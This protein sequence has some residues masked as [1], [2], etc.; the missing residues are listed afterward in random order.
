MVGGRR[1]SRGAVPGGA[2]AA[3]RCDP[4]AANPCEISPAASH[5][6]PRRHPLQ[7]TPLFVRCTSSSIEGSTPPSRGS[8]ATRM[9]PPL[10]IIFLAAGYEEHPIG[11]SLPPS[12]RAPSSD[13]LLSPVS[14]R[15]QP[16]TSQAPSRGGRGRPLIGPP[17]PGRKKTTSRK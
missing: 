3:T 8:R 9:M 14:R 4:P 12:P 10:G 6:V 16:S 1:S 11:I 13:P 15:P 5:P 17:P 2:A 7:L